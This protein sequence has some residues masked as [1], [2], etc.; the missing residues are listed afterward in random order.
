MKAV[1]SLAAALI[2]SSLAAA[3]SAVIYEFPDGYSAALV[4]SSDIAM[5]AETV[6]VVPA[7]AVFDPHGDGYWLIPM[8]DVTCVFHLEN[9]TDEAQEVTVGFP[10]DAKFGN[11]YTVFDDATLAA[12][13]DSIQADEERD[14]WHRTD[15]S[16]GEDASELLPEDLGF[17]AAA[18]GE[19]L[20]VSYRTCRRDPDMELVWDPLMAVWDMR[21]EP[22]ERVRLVNTYRTSWDYYGGGPYGDYT[23]RYIVTSGNTWAGPI[24]HAV[25]SIEVPEELP[26]PMLS[27]TLSVWWSWS[28]SPTVDGRVVTWERHDWEPDE[29]LQVAVNTQTNAGH[30]ENQL[31]APGMA[32]SIE[33]TTDRLLPSVARELD[34]YQAWGPSYAAETQL[35][36]A[37]AVVSLVA[38]E[39]PADPGV[40]AHFPVGPDADGVYRLEPMS[41]EGLPPLSEM[42]SVVAEVREQL[43]EDSARAAAAGYLP[44]LP[45]FATRWAWG[46]SALDRYAAEPELE[47]L[48]LDL[49]LRME[50]AADGERIDAPDIAAFYRLTGWYYPGSGFDGPLPVAREKVEAYAGDR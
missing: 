12:H 9:L 5:V 28:G 40:L 50:A 11:A 16:S 44:F 32:H 47:E 49:L 22:G 17:T 25:I 46:E 30:W 6:T 45:M 19:P 39:V 13:L 38:G 35:R 34:D 18:D 8:M 48:Y 33:W 23:C 29:N 14:R 24:G 15:G 27:D 1:S 20:E 37:E 42:R 7:R 2:I 10:L 26:P 31:S 36:I 43:S 3:D 21:F 4:N 41:G